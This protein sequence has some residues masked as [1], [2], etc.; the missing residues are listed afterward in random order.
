MYVQLFLQGNTPDK[1]VEILVSSSILE[2]AMQE[3]RNLWL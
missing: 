3:L 1:L 2:L